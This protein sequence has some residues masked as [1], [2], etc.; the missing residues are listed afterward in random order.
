MSDPLKP[1]I[2]GGMA[3]LQNPYNQAIHQ[4]FYV[5]CMRCG[6]RTEIRT[7]ESIAVSDWNNRPTE[8]ILRSEVERLKAALKSISIGMLYP[9]EFAQSVLEGRWNPILTDTP[10]DSAEVK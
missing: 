4:Q 3:V 10:E 2:C 8:D 5:R 9:K 7:I 1:C 6:L